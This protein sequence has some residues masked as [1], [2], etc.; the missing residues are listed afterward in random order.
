MVAMRVD[1]TDHVQGFAILHERLNGPLILVLIRCTDPCLRRQ[2]FLIQTGCQLLQQVVSLPA[3]PQASTLTDAH[4]VTSRHARKGVICSP[5]IFA[6]A[7]NMVFCASF[8][9]NVLW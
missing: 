2:L 8:Q 1:L 5:S 7:T 6:E 4:A 3:S 9:P